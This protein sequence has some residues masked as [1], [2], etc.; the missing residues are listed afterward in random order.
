VENLAD[1]FLGLGKEDLSVLR[2]VEAGMRD[3]EWV[4]L[5]EIARFCGLAE[6]KVEFRLRSLSQK[7]LVFLENLHYQ[8]YQIGFHAYDLLALADLVEKGFVTGMGNRVGVGKESVVYEGLGDGPL[9]IKF[10]RQGQTS[11][12]HVRRARGHLQ[13]HPRGS[14][15]YA[16]NLAARHEF[17]VMGRLYPAVSI[18]RPIACSRHALAMEQIS[19]SLLQKVELADPGECLEQLLM[20]VQKAF[21]VGIVH[22]DLSEFN[23][24][25]TAEGIKIIDWPQAVDASHHNAVE[26]LKRDLHNILGFFARRYGIERELEEVLAMVVVGGGDLI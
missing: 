7:K 5:Q 14:W 25:V 17:R 9:I 23:V 20:N 19:G 18:P 15:L 21:Q 1:L 2:A 22:A 3:H 6:R 12:K 24:M 16:A 11:F 26:L 4:P 10:H 8:G 13:D